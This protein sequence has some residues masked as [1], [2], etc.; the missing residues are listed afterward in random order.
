MCLSWLL[1]PTLLPG[2]LAGWL[3]PCRLSRSIHELLGAAA[4]G[5]RQSPEEAAGE[6]APAD[7][8]SPCA[9]SASGEWRQQQEQQ[10]ADEPVVAAAAEAVMPAGSDVDS[11]VLLHPERAATAAAA[12]AG[13][14]GPL[15][16]SGHSQAGSWAVRTPPP[17]AEAP[18]QAPVLPQ[19]RRVRQQGQGQ[20]LQ[21]TP[22]MSREG[23]GNLEWI[24]AVSKE[25]LNVSGWGGGWALSG[26]GRGRAGFVEV[27]ATRGW[28]WGAGAACWKAW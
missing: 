2:W 18:R 21:P 16:D 12:V 28:A 4:S 13:A 17:A 19:L 10:Q 25:W 6:E 15:S 22:S 27:R 14:K 8:G 9:S 24:S 7:T 26:A 1:P 3:P 20:G 5:G 23:S 11:D